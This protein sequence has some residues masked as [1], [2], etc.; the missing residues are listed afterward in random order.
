MIG[1]RQTSK[2]SHHH[3]HHH[4]PLIGIEGELEKVKE[5]G[6]EKVGGAIGI[7]IVAAIVVAVSEAVGE[8]EVIVG[9]VGAEVETTM[10]V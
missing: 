10:G 8:V 6:V 5:I 9:I 7:I 1:S 4:P 3:L 2:L